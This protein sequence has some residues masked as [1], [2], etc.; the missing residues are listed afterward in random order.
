MS[1]KRISKFSTSSKKVKAW[2]LKTTL[3]PSPRTKTK[4]EKNQ[5]SC[6]SDNLMAQSL[7]NP[8]KLDLRKDKRLIYSPKICSPNFMR[9]LCSRLP[10]STPWAIT[11]QQEVYTIKTTWSKSMC[12]MPNPRFKRMLTI[13]T[14]A[15]RLLKSGWAV[16]IKMIGEPRSKC[17]IDKLWVLFQD[18]SKHNVWIFTQLLSLRHNSNVI[19]TVKWFRTLFLLRRQDQTSWDHVN[20]RILWIAEMAQVLI[21]F[22]LEVILM[23]VVRC[24]TIESTTTLAPKAF[25]RCFHSRIWITLLINSPKLIPA[26][27]WPRKISKLPTVLIMRIPQKCSCNSSWITIIS[28][29]PPLFHQT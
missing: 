10:L 15:F 22:K 25:R 8:K 27:W 16:I 1:S 18:P 9:R 4:I 11:L 23:K 21:L 13:W 17:S 20:I 29:W 7:Y 14:T 12:L 2:E 5:N 26:E 24:A 3:D 6:R 28:Q 19:W